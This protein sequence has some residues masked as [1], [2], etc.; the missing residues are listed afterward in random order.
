VPLEHDA[1]ISV[2]T[3]PGD[4][5]AVTVK[6]TDGGENRMAVQIHYVSEN[7]FAELMLSIDGMGGDEMTDVQVNEV[8][9][10]MLATPWVQAQL[11]PGTKRVENLNIS[12]LG[13]VVSVDG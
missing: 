12:G 6:L 8:A 3:D 10:A 9:D 13:R 2:G 4:T 11:G 1:V 7:P 5:E